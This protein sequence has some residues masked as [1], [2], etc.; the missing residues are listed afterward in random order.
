MCLIQGLEGCQSLRLVCG[1][2]D[3]GARERSAQQ[4]ES[5]LLLQKL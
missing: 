5:L 2:G 3:V 1:D 4:H